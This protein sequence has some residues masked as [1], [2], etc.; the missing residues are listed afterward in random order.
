MQKH[1]KPNFFFLQIGDWGWQ[2]LKGQEKQK[3]HEKMGVEHRR[4]SIRCIGGN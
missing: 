1:P 4:P 3:P 2:P